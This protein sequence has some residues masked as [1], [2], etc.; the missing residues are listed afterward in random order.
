MAQQTI[1]HG[2]RGSAVKVGEVTS[3][4]IERADNGFTVRISTKQK[5]VRGNQP[6]AWDAGNENEVFESV[7]KMVNRVREAFAD[8]KLEK[9]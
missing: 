9:E 2:E 1:A 8:V 6:Y 7:D 4:N 3:I 5:P